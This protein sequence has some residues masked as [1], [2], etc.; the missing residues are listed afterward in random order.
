MWTS[1]LTILAPM[2]ALALASLTVGAQPPSVSLQQAL[3]K[4]ID[5]F[6]L[7]NV[8]ISE[9]FRKLSE[10]TGVKFVVD[11]QTMACLPYGDQTRLDV[12]MKNATIRKDLSRVLAPE[13]LQWTIEN[14]LVRIMPGEALARMCRRASYD[15]LAALGKLH[16]EKITPAAG[17][18]T[19]E[20]LRKATDDK[21]L[22]PAFQ[23][24]SGDKA[25]ALAQAD[26]ALPCTGAEWLDRLCQQGP[27]TWYL[28]G[29]QIIILDRKAQVARQLQ[30]QVSLRYQNEKLITVL[31]DLARKGRVRL[32]MEPGV[33]NY[34]PSEIRTNMDLVMA[35]ATID[36]ALQV[37]S[38]A[39]GL[40]FV[41]TEDGV[42][43]APS[44]K[45]LKGVGADTSARKTPF[46]VR[47]NMAGPGGTNIEVY[48][49]PD[50][51][52]DEMVQQIEAEKANVIKRWMAGKPVSATTAP[53]FP[54]PKEE[55]H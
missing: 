50:E 45:L 41:K 10:K 30:Q 24:T 11:D 6:T 2:V 35:D 29:D 5:A 19:I 15:E 39:T 12:R 14:D 23:I 17:S 37:I 31:L 4:P 42:R 51:L 8:T 54:T 34:V 21:E 33:L 55:N 22:D 16:L 40:E 53:A 44:E 3:D 26:R 32:E 28:W 36:Q 13:A 27:W 49:R 52:P 25:A 20:L 38:G 47:M 43:V 48:F 7:E 18:S 1:K 9:V 46:F